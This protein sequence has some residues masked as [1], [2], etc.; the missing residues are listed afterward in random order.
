M[1]SATCLRQDYI[2]K[3]MFL[4]YINQ[5]VV[6]DEFCGEDPQNIFWVRKMVSLRSFTAHFA[7]WETSFRKSGA[8]LSELKHHFNKAQDAVAT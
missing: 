5:K 7:E 8:S 3:L 6:V 4:R 1:S 2:C